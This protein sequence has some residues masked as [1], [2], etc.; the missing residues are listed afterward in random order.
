MARIRTVKPEYWS[1]EQVMACSRNSRLLFIGLW[2]FADDC[3][4]LADSAKSIKAQIFPGDDD[5]NSENVRGMLDELSSNG[6]LLK[7]EVNGKAYLEITGWKH[8]KID[9][10]QPPKHPPPDSTNA[11]RSFATDLT[12]LSNPTD[13]SL[14]GWGPKARSLA[15]ALPSGA[16]AREP[17]SE[18]AAAKKPSEVT[19]AELDA[20]IAARRVVTS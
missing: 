19:R 3:G 9:R 15:S 2:N 17:G 10:P 14:R 4:R 1:S 13:P 5:V 16:L 12:Y 20:R 7:Y 18:Q 8:Q 6:L 11:R